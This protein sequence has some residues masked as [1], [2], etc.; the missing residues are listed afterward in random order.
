M[1]AFVCVDDEEKFD[2][3]SIMDAVITPLPCVLLIVIAVASA[4]SVLVSVSDP[5]VLLVIVAAAVTS[6]GAIVVPDSIVPPS[7][8]ILMIE[9]IDERNATGPS[10]SAGIRVCVAL[11]IFT[12]N[13]W[14]TDISLS[15]GMFRRGEAIESGPG[16]VTDV[17]HII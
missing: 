15:D 12:I 13:A 1:A 10:S 4:A 5:S 14:G 6:A 7:F 17:E 11:H 3:L 8:S 16:T 9:F 2:E